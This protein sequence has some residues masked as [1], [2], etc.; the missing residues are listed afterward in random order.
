MIDIGIQTPGKM[1]R[2]FRRTHRWFKWPAFLAMALA[3][4]VP[5]VMRSVPSQLGVGLPWCGSHAS[6]ADHDRTG[7]PEGSGHAHDVCGYCSLLSHAPLAPG[8]SHGVDTWERQHR[9]NPV[10]GQTT[11]AHSVPRDESRS[12]RGPPGPG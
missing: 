9:P 5:V 10:S 6:V 2:P 4:L 7:A 12:P 8:M 1:K 11:Y 3:T